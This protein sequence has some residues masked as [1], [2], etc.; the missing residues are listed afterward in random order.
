MIAPITSVGPPLAKEFC[1]D[2]RR[3][4]P[5]GCPSR[6]S[7]L[8]S[9]VLVDRKHQAT[10]P[11]WH[12]LGWKILHDFS[13][14]VAQPPDKA[15]EVEHRTGRQI[16][17]HNQA[18]RRRSTLS[19]RP[20]DPSGGVLPVAWHAIP[21]H[22]GKA[23]G[24]QIIDHLA[25]EQARIERATTAEGAEKEIGMGKLADQQLC[26]ADFVLGSIAVLAPA[27]RLCMSQ[28]VIADPVGLVTG[29][30][31]AR[32]ALGVGEL[33]SDY[34]EARAHALAAEHVEDMVGH[35]GLGAVVE[36][37]RDF[38]VHGTFISVR[39]SPGARQWVYFAYS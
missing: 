22:A 39:P 38:H 19:E 1:R 24:A 36:A 2:I 6:L 16:V 23:T 7:P 21:Q 20:L 31:G 8:Y 25:I 17:Q 5:G 26:A 12:A 28:A 30:L 32:A 13:P 11:Y 29:T 33:F 27:K 4:R 10:A 14:V 37:E 9:R 34:E 35:L 15:L 18:P 3:L